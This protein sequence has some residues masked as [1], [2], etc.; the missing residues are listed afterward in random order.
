MMGVF[1][2]YSDLKV[3]IKLIFQICHCGFL[4]H[5]CVEGSRLIMVAS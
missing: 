5:G 4:L 1:L 3:G 2:G